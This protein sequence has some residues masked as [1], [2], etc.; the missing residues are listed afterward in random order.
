MHSLNLYK[1]EMSFSSM[2]RYICTTFSKNTMPIFLKTK[3]LLFIGLLVYS[4]SVVCFQSETYTAKDTTLV[5]FF[6]SFLV[7]LHSFHS[8]AIYFTDSFHYTCMHL[9][10]TLYEMGKNLFIFMVF[11]ELPQKG[12][13]LLTLF[14]P[15]ILI[16]LNRSFMTPTNATFDTYK[17]SSIIAHTSFDATPQSCEFY[18]EI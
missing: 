14:I 4:S 5:V 6:V 2:F 1:H 17:Y 10:M 13:A 18:S 12:G 15:C 9:L 8:Y 11:C 16:E 7:P 3:C